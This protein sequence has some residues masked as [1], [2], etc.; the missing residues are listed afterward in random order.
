M[1]TLIQ[2]LF[3]AVFMLVS[4]MVFVF[5]FALMPFWF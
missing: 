2:A 1:E 3:L 4:F 5:L